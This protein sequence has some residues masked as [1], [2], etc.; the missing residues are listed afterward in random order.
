MEAATREEGKKKT[1]KSQL[2]QGRVSVENN[3]LPIRGVPKLHTLVT[4]WCTSHFLSS[5]LSGPWTLFTSG[6]VLS[7]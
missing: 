7:L 1:D 5:Q 4:S 3:V 6:C 2:G